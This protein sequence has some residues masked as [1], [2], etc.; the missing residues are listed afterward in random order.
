[1]NARMARRICSHF[2]A[3]FR[4]YSKYTFLA[5]SI[6]SAKWLALKYHFI[7][8]IVCRRHP[9]PKYLLWRKCLVLLLFFFLHSTRKF[10]LNLEIVFV[11]FFFVSRYSFRRAILC[12]CSGAASCEP[13]RIWY[14][15]FNDLVFMRCLVQISKGCA[16][17]SC[18]TAN[19]PEGMT[20]QKNQ[21]KHHCLTTHMHSVWCALRS[22]CS[23]LLSFLDSAHLHC[24]MHMVCN[25][26]N[27]S[28]YIEYGAVNEQSVDSK[29]CF[30]F[31]VF[32]CP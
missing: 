18:A 22:P 4:A 16:R 21:W 7:K 3:I 10:P 24:T 19:I 5:K 12:R 17:C 32:I 26:R 29:R 20:E 30:W 31:S 2:Q 1:M 28:D 8:I 13:Y 25:R 14:F 23:L 27:K 6:F 11:C 9:A 15:A